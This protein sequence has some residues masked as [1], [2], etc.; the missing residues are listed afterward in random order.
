MGLVLC[1]IAGRWI[2]PRGG[3]TRDQ[4]SSL[5]LEY[6][7]IAADILEI[8]G[9]FEEEEVRKVLEFE[10]SLLN[11]RWPVILIYNSRYPKYSSI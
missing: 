7:A 8:F 9:A 11:T 2:L 5:L 3:I 10:I 1:V 4:L 6:V